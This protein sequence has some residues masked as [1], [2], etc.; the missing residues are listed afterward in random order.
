MQAGRRSSARQPR[1]RRHRRR[2]SSRSR[3]YTTR[4]LPDM[5][6]W[7][8]HIDGRA[9][10]SW[11]TRSRRSSRP[12]TCPP[13]CFGLW[14][15]LALDRGA[16]AVGRRR[17]ARSCSAAR[18]ACASRGALLAGVVYGFSLW[19][20]TWLSYP[21]TSVWA[22][23]PW[24]LVAADRVARR[25]DLPVG[26]A[27]AAVVG[28]QFLCGHPESSFHALLATTVFFACAAPAHRGGPGGGRGRGVRRRAR[29]RAAL[30]ALVLLPFA[31]L[32]WHSADLRPAGG[33]VGRLVPAAQVRARALPARTIRAGRPRPAASCSCSARA[34]YAGA[35]PLMLAAAALVLRPSRGRLAVAAAGR[36]VH[37]G[38]PRHPADLPGRDRLP[39]VL[40]AATTRAWS[41]STCWP[42]RCSPAGG[43]TT[44]SRAAG[45]ARGAARCWPSPR[46]CSCCR[47]PTSSCAARTSLDALAGRA[48]RGLGVRR[49]PPASEA[50]PA[51]R[52]S[53]AAPGCCVWVGVGARRAGDHGRG[54]AAPAPP[55]AARRRSPPRRSLL[56]RARPRPRRHGLQP[57]DRPRRGDRGP[58]RPRSGCSSG[59]S[60]R[61]S[62][63]PETSRRT[64][65]PMTFGLYDAR[66]YDLPVEQRFDRL[67]R[68]ELSPEFPSQVGELPIRHPALAPE[69]HRGPAAGAAPAW[70]CTAVMQPTTDPEL[71]VPGLALVHPGPDARLYALDGAAPRAAV[72]G[73]QEVVASEDAALDAVTATGFDPTRVA[74]TERALPGLPRAASAEPAGAARIVDI[75]PDRLEVTATARAGGPARRLGRLVPGL[76][77]DGRRAARRRRARE[78]RVPRRARRPR[79]APRRVRLRPLSWRIGWIVSLLAVLGIAAAGLAP[80]RLRRGARRGSAPPA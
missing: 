62:S 46:A 69:G 5:P 52:R 75:E 22:L 60:R 42:S 39:A 18:S 61:A 63:P 20:V 32:L 76:D 3:E 51:L 64:T 34:F 21:H 71:H 67:W 55:A 49:D 65:I 66:G 80:R 25:P 30:A 4:D 9:A 57:G 13:T 59:R 11:P 74:V 31:E 43:W 8:P 33:H 73:A 77:G 53:S 72:V 41:C 2:C 7:N 16:E 14:R 38:R 48:A 56:R 40:A 29:G 54:A 79:R 45:S 1:A 36:S 28:V 35:L 23:I 78:L 15:A 68:T 50:W 37:G 17:S 58:P 70:A 27:L 24:L 10:R 47:S 6:L 26:A 19:M 12:S 44:C